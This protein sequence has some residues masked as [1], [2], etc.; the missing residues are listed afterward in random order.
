M[1]IT[2]N[3]QLLNPLNDAEC[4]AINVCRELGPAQIIM[5]PYC[6][7]NQT[8]LVITCE[9]Q[10]DD[11]ELMFGISYTDVPNQ[12]STT[13]TRLE[14]AKRLDVRV[15]LGCAA[16]NPEILAAL[17]NTQVQT[18]PLSDDRVIVPIVDNPGQRPSYWQVEIIPLENNEAS[19]DWG[20]VLDYAYS[21]TEDASLIFSPGNPRS[22][23]FMLTSFPHPKTRS[24]GFMY[25]NEAIFVG[26]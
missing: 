1:S 9:E 24:R 3:G 13:P 20:I 6:R 21:T 7:E 4:R 26:S 14:N 8:P 25:F 10:R 18:D 12:C 11:L 17:L 16:T 2:N 15:S 23:N 5:T 19:S 22:V